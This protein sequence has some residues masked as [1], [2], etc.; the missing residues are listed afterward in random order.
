M[1]SGLAFQSGDYSRK[2]W[3]G[4]LQIQNR[5]ETQKTERIKATI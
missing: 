2:E 4:C 5:K 3:G 1:Q